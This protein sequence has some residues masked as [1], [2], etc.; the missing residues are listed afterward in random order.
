MENLLSLITNIML[1]LNRISPM[2]NHRSSS[3]HVYAP[4]P[5]SSHVLG[6]LEAMT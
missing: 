2:T 6:Q 4:H 1:T 3:P 5:T